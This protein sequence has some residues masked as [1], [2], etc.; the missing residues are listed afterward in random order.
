MKLKTFVTLVEVITGSVFYGIGILS[1][2]A[3]KI[4]GEVGIIAGLYCFVAGTLFMPFGL[5]RRYYD[6]RY[7]KKMWENEEV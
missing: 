1:L 3:T 4:L 5:I 7:G 6:W 2:M